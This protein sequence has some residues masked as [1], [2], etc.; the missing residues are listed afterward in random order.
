MF[1]IISKK[2]FE[3]LNPLNSEIKAN[4]LTF[5]GELGYAKAGIMFIKSKFIIDNQIRILKIGHKYIDEVKM[6]LSLIKKLGNVDVIIK[7]IG[8]SGILKKAEALIKN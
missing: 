8:V 5:L 6:G 1:K 7:S 2:P 3:A 4:L